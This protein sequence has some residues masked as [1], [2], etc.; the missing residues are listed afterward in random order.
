M[1]RRVKQRVCAWMLMCA[2]VLPLG[3]SGEVHAAEIKSPYLTEQAVGKAP[4]VTAYV[5]GSKMTKEAKVSA[6]LGEIE[7]TK[8]GEVTAFDESGEAIHYIVLLDNSGSVNRGQFDEAKSQ[9]VKLRKSLDEGDKMSLY[10]V[11]ADNP[12]GEKTKILKTTVKAD[13]KKKAKDTEKIQKIKYNSSPTSMTVLYRSLNQILAE[14]TSPTMRTVVLLVTDGED[15][16]EGKDIDKVSTAEEVKAATVPVYGVF[17]KRDISGLDDKVEYTKNKILAEKNCRGYYYDCTSGSADSVKKAFSTIE[18]ILEKKTYV[19]HLS[20]PTNKTVGKSELNLTIDN[21][22]S[23]A[24]AIDYSDYEADDSAPEI[25]G[26][27]EKSSADTIEFTL[28]DN[29][30]VNTD[31]ANQKSN[32]KL[33][34]TKNGKTGKVWTIESVSAVSEGDQT[35]VTLKVSEKLYTGD[36]VLSI[37][38]IQDNSQDGN[39]M[40]DSAE[41]TIKDGVNATAAGIKNGFKSYWWILLI[42]LVIIIGAL[43][44]RAVRKKAVKIVEVNPD[45]LVKADKRKIRL[46]ITDRA[47][48]IKEVEWEV[49]GSLFVGRSDICNIYFDDDRLS[50]QHFVIEVSKMGCYIEDLESTNGTF[51]NGIKITGRRML[52]DGDVITA[53]REK[54]IFHMPK[55]E[56]LVSEE[57][58][59]AGYEE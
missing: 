30:G 57:E 26:E 14:Q 13:D 11:G 41:F 52:L 40:S 20:A 39:K 8:E 36:Y 50:K 32:Y 35:N 38:D 4:N 5:T 59:H 7:L 19:V 29:N 16:S 46:T 49:E 45:D 2:L 15:D 27:V 48:M 44:I 34:S 22:A 17:L 23:N 37:S 42:L 9:L 24:V 43:I 3:V 6:K 25:A 31:D 53:G 10:T 28:Q 21:T 51:V 12:Q 54:L 18:K 1:G 55:N 47:G 58:K 56:P 33:Q